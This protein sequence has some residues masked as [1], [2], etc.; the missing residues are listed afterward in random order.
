M[1]VEPDGKDG[2]YAVQVLTD[3]KVISEW[4][5]RWAGTGLWYSRLAT[6]YLGEELGSPDHDGSA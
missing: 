5:A 1:E 2:R 4:L 3:E 6:E